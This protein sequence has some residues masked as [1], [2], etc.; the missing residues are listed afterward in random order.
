MTP[1]GLPHSEI[2]GLTLF[3]ATRGLSQITTSFI[4]CL[5][6]GIHRMPLVTYRN[7]LLITGYEQLINAF[8]LVSCTVI[9][10]L[11]LFSAST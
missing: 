3:S 5:C 2:H 9:E 10:S 11:T 6:Q 7:S 8:A 4:A 1:A